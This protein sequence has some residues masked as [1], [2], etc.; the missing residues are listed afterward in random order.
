[1]Q[2]WLAAESEAKAVERGQKLTAEWV[3]QAEIA[4]QVAT[5]A[6]QPEMLLYQGGDKDDFQAMC[7]RYSIKT[8]E[9]WF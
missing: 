4:Q 8:L 3:E 6:R 9:D 1:M 2:G 5:L 7:E